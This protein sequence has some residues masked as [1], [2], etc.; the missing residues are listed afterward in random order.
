MCVCEYVCINSVLFPTKH[1]FS[2]KANFLDLCS[3]FP[4]ISLHVRSASSQGTECFRPSLCELDK[5]LASNA[6][7]NAKTQC[8]VTAICWRGADITA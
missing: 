3:G 7:P 5:L 4:G 1:I 6:E 2:V 8:G